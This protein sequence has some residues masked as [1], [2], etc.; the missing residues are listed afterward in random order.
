MH[1]TRLRVLISVPPNLA[2]DEEPLFAS[3]ARSSLVFLAQASPLV[4]GCPKIRKGSPNT[5]MHELR[6]H[7]RSSLELNSIQE[8]GDKE[9]PKD[10]SHLKSCVSFY[11]CPRAPFYRETKELLHSEN[12]LL[13][14]RNI[15]NVNMYTNAFYIPRFAGLISYI[16]KPAT[17]SHA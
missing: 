13:N 6:I 15:P 1:V 16:Y 14:L 3:R 11:T 10:C 4:G 12:T 7:E 2:Q 17:S 8:G 9:S 5:E